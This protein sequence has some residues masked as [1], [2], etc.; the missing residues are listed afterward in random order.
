MLDD[1]RLV[2]EITEARL[3]C[4]LCLDCKTRPDISY[5]P[6]CTITTCKCGQFDTLPEWQPKQAMRIWN[7]CVMSKSMSKP[8]RGKQK[9]RINN[10]TK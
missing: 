4:A 1:D 6:G 3:L 9:Q 7:A 8:N 10:E 5:E 2:N